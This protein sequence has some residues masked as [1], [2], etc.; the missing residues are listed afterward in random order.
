MGY[1][2]YYVVARGGRPLTEYE[3]LKSVREEL[4]LLEERA[5]GWQVW[6][7]EAAGEAAPGIGSMRQL[8]QE[9]GAPALFG[10]VM[11][12]ECAVVEGAAADSGTWTACLAPV[13]MAT[14][15]GVGE[16][17]LEDYFLPPDNATARAVTWAAEAGFSACEPLLHEAFTIGADPSA[18]TLFFRLLDLLGVAER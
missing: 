3:A 10:Y 12:S 18:E 13:A 6:E 7:C 8:A 1:W 11:D 5:A 17:D 9:S 14:L 2:G 4:V 16:R 15:L